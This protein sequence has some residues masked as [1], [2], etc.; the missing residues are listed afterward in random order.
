[1]SFLKSQEGKNDQSKTQSTKET[2]L[3]RFLPYPCLSEDRWCKV[4]PWGHSHA[5]LRMPAEFLGEKKL[6][7]PHSKHECKAKVLHLFTG[8]KSVAY[9]NL[10]EDRTK[11]GVCLKRPSRTPRTRKYWVEYGDTTV[12]WENYRDDTRHSILYPGTIEWTLQWLLGSLAFIL[13]ASLFL[14]HL[15]GL[16]ACKSA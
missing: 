6:K 16:S 13:W 5:Q 9:K 12:C 7:S 14:E 2:K 1:M 11:L 10:L 4:P 8:N 15:Y 3:Y